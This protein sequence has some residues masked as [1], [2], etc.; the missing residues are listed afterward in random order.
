MEDMDDIS[1]LTSQS[2]TPPSDT[3]SNSS[4]LLGGSGTS[5]P[6]GNSSDLS[7]LGGLDFGAPAATMPMRNPSHS[8]GGTSMDAL[9]PMNMQQQQQGNNTGGFRSS[10]GGPRGS[11]NT[12]SNGSKEGQKKIGSPRS[13]ALNGFL[14]GL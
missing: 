1:S 5:T 14:G 2:P 8:F 4:D 9:N 7:G 13:Q 12:Q 6:T 11:I 10:S 3:G